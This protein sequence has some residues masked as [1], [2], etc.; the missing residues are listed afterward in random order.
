MVKQN[1]TTRKFSDVAVGLYR[2]KNKTRIHTETHRR[3][4]ASLY[5][6]GNFRHPFLKKKGAEMR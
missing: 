4:K 2:E 5:S 1:N 6:P 3:F